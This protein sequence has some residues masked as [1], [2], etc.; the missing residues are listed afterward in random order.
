MIRLN[1]MIM[2][3]SVAVACLIV[4]IQNTPQLWHQFQ[5]WRNEGV[6]CEHSTDDGKAMHYGKDCL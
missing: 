3:V 1:Q 5:L 2:G 6:S 4:G